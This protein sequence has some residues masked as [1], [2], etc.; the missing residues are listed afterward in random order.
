M[1][2]ND[3][4]VLTRGQA[5][6]RCGKFVPEDHPFWDVAMARLSAAGKNDERSMLYERAV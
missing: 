5:P 3:A 6:R 1:S 4:V 2:H